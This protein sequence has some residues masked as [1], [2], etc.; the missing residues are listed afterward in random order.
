MKAYGRVYKWVEVK[1][2]NGNAK[3]FLC[4]W[5]AKSLEIL[6]QMKQ[7]VVWKHWINNIT[8]IILKHWSKGNKKFLLLKLF[9][10]LMWFK[11]IL[12]L[13]IICTTWQNLMLS[14]MRSLLLYIYWLFIC[15]VCFVNNFFPYLYFVALFRTVKTFESKILN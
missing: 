11:G 7:I 8:K 12:I 5:E 14:H 10:S 2:V 9:L 6:N 13:F 4:V 15:L 3:S 1:K